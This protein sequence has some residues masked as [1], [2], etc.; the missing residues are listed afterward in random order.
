MSMDTRDGAPVREVEHY[1]DPTP[2]NPAVTEEMTE[3]Q[4]DTKEDVV[5]DPVITPKVQGP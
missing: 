3:D 4:D 1:V 2:F 5:V